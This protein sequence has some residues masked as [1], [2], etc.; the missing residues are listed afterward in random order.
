MCRKLREMSR[1]CIGMSRNY[2][3]QSLPQCG[4]SR[5]YLGSSRNYRGSSHCCP[6][7]SRKHLDSSRKYRFSSRKWPEKSCKSIHGSRPSL[8]SG[9]C[10]SAICGSRCELKRC[11]A[12][13]CGNWRGSCGCRLTIGS[14]PPDVCGTFQTLKPR[15]RSL[16]GSPRGRRGADFAG[17]ERP[18]P[19]PSSPRPSSPDHPIPLPG[20]R[21]RPARFQL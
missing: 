7:S 14:L 3:D 5:N 4:S 21:G 20:R 2:Q 9:H 12:S 11:G 17:L 1:K 15:R 18:R 16:C 13:F 8:R 10:D 6:G 19:G